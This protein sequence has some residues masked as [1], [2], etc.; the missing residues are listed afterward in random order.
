MDKNKDLDKDYRYTWIKN[1]D[2]DKYYRY[3]WIKIKI[4]INTVD[5]HG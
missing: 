2:L 3:T 1:K 5:I 4:W